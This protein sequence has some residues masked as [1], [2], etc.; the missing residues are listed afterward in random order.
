MD[1]NK[2]YSDHQKAVM[3]ASTAPDKQAREVHLGDASNI[4]GQIEGHQ[5][6]LGA[7]ASSAW[8]AVKMRSDAKRA[9]GAVA[10]E[11]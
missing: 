3:R 5:L 4:A 8:T 9:R 2:K 10:G 11:L 1:L 6:N 7:A